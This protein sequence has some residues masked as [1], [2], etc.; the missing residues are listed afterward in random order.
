MLRSTTY[1]NSASSPY[2]LAL[3]FG[4]LYMICASIS[5]AQP[6]TASSSTY[7][8]NDIIVRIN[9]DSIRCTIDAVSKTTISYHIKKFGPDPKNKI[10]PDQVKT[11][12]YKQQWYTQ[13]GIS[14]MVEQ[15][16]N[17]ILTG[18]INDAIATYARLM[19]GD[20]GNALLLAE[21]AYA[22]ALAGLYD[23]ALF[24][25]DRCWSMNTHSTDIN[26]FTAQVFAL[27]GFD[28]LAAEFWTVTGRHKAP[29]WISQK[30][31]ILLQ[32]YKN[33]RPF[34]AKKEREKLISDFALANE[35]AAK[36]LY[37]QSIGLFNN[38]ILYYPDEY[39][40]YIGYSI[41]LE[42]AGA[43]QQA[44]RAMEQAI[45]LLGDNVEDREKKTVLEQRLG[46]VKNRLISLPPDVLPGM[47]PKKAFDP[48][49]PQ[50]MAYAGGMWA[51]SYLN[52]NFRVG[53]FT[54]ASSNAS[55][56]FGMSR[57]AGVS[58]FNVGV[59]YYLRTGSLV[60]G[61]GINIFTGNGN[62]SASLKLSLGLSKMNKKRSSSFD[63][64]LDINPGLLKGSATT[65]TLSVGQSIYFG[66]RK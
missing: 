26:Y 4:C 12:F 32:R 33:T 6:N 23:A 27:M 21:S 41:T 2:R 17:N 5:L 19:A 35:L 50:L 7:P 60:S 44:T 29:S 48:S 43:L 36:N 62:T 14:A 28:E 16:R 56:D 38:I 37:F 40:P 59:A 42:K 58:V 31:A 13:E 8:N 61:T 55:I 11:Y 3:V 64:F 63:V 65:I 18:Q 39:L 53:Y 57:N 52:M 20:T 1:R 24:R 47:L 30:A 10:A 9:G 66:R 51:K 15:A 45:S 49:A 25:L 22:L 46:H 54:A 34:P